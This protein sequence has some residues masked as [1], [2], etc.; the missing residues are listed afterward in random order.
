MVKVKSLLSDS[1]LAEIK[2]TARSGLNPFRAVVEG[3]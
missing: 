2:I 3:R 1:E